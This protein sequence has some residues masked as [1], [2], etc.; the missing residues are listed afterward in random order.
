MLSPSKAM[1]VVTILTFGVAESAAQEQRKD[2]LGPIPVDQQS[3]PQ[4]R[5]TDLPLVQRDATAF[6]R[7]GERTLRV[8]PRIVGGVPAPIGAYPWQVSIGL[9][10]NPHSIGHFCGGSIVS[11][12]F[13]V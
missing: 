8:E 7:S 2:S 9:K 1:V 11:A 10:D 3:R 12:S 5:T 4:G 13:V 6:A